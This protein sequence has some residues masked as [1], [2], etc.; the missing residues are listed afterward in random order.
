MVALPSKAVSLMKEKIQGSLLIWKLIAYKIL[1]LFE[2][3]YLCSLHKYLTIKLVQSSKTKMNNS[4]IPMKINCICSG[5]NV[6]TR[7]YQKMGLGDDLVSKFNFIQEYIDNL[8]VD[9]KVLIII[10]IYSKMSYKMVLMK[11]QNK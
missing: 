8:K 5:C 3:I 9:S 7:F 1:L 11:N 6:L 2:S 10:Q 4:S